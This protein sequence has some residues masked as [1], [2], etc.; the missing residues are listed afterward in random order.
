M[1]SPRPSRV[2]VEVSLSLVVPEG[3][4]L[5]VQAS[6]RYEPMDPYAVHVVFHAGGEE[7]CPEVSW[8]FARQLLVDGLNEPA[9]LGDVRVWPWLGDDGPVAALALSSP[10]GHALFEVPR[11]SLEDF[12]ARTYSQV[13]LGAE[14]R[15]LD[16]DATLANLLG[17]SGSEPR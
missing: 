12:V 3:S 5:P 1:R 2:Q 13:P 7:P 11:E 10:D 4:A 17:A 8:S 9:G 15:Y 14:S 16:L 6:L